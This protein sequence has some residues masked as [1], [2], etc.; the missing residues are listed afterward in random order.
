MHCAQHRERELCKATTQMGWEC[1]C[2]CHCS[3][4][5]ARYCSPKHGYEGPEAL[6]A[7]AYRTVPQCEGASIAQPAVKPR[8]PGCH[9]LGFR[10]ENITH[11]TLRIYPQN[12][13]APRAALLSGVG[14]CGLGVW[15]GRKSNNCSTCTASAY[16]PHC[17]GLRFLGKVC[18]HC[19]LEHAL[20]RLKIC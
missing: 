9:I 10:I 20:A 7:Y 15:V 11:K 17:L 12:M 19:H 13:G 16:T 5:T 18:R 6:H 3:L 14:S 8:Q 2:I 1:A 4:D